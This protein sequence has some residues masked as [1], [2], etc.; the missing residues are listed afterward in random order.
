MLARIYVVF[1]TH[2]AATPRLIRPLHSRRRRLSS[3]FITCV[4]CMLSPLRRSSDD[5]LIAGTPRAV[6]GIPHVLCTVQL[7]PIY[8][9]TISTEKQQ[10]WR[11]GVTESP[12]IA[13]LFTQQACSALPSAHCEST[14]CDVVTRIR[15]WFSERRKHHPFSANSCT[16]APIL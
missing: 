5:Q 2:T 4:R 1:N 11:F 14:I 6:A 16:H 12:T 3:E 7:G 9:Y 13:P 15:I 10:C 8:L